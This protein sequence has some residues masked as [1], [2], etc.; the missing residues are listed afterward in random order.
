MS[1]DYFLVGKDKLGKILVVYSVVV[2]TREWMG[3][4]EVVILLPCFFSVAV[5]ILYVLFVYTMQ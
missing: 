5:Y 4:G 2:M 3:K 1:V